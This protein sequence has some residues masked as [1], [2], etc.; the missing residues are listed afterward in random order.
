[1]TK[2]GI[3]TRF[4]YGYCKIRELYCEQLCRV[5]YLFSPIIA[6]FRPASSFLKHVQT[7]FTVS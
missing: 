4:S 7:F 6:V 2:H 3:L 5:V 1:M